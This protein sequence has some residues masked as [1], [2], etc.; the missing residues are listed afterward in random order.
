MTEWTIFE[1]KWPP[2]PSIVELIN[3]FALSSTEWRRVYE[4]HDPG[5]EEPRRH[6]R[7]V[8][9]VNPRRPCSK[10]PNHF[11]LHDWQERR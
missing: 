10:D 3:R 4:G 2:P 6:G 5:D 8:C 11:W 1:I 7:L 9:S